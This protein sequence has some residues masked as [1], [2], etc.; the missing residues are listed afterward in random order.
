LLAVTW[1]N[2][3]KAEIMPGL[4]KQ[5]LTEESLGHTNEEKAWEELKCRWHFDR[6]SLKIGSSPSWDSNVLLVWMN[7]CHK[8]LFTVGH[9]GN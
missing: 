7:I 6:I 2:S 5:S 1:G 4:E 3:A 9:L 8:T